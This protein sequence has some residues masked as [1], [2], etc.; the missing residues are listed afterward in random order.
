MGYTINLLPHESA[1]QLEVS[2]EQIRNRAR[3]FVTEY[4]AKGEVTSTAEGILENLQ[5]GGFWYVF[6]GVE[7]RLPEFTPVDLQSILDIAVNYA[8]LMP[9]GQGARPGLSRGHAVLHEKL[10]QKT[11][12][13]FREAL[14]PDF[15]KRLNNGRL[16]ES[17]PELAGLSDSYTVVRDV[18]VKH[19]DDLSDD[20][21][22]Q[23]LAIFKRN[24]QMVEHLDLSPFRKTTLDRYGSFLERVDAKKGDNVRDLEILVAPYL[25][26]LADLNEEWEFEIPPD[27]PGGIKEV[28][29]KPYINQYLQNSDFVRNALARALFLISESDSAIPTV[30]EYL[31]N[32]QELVDRM[33]ALDKHKS[34]RK[35]ILLDIHY[36]DKASD[37]LSPSAQGELKGILKAERRAKRK[38]QRKIRQ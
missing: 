35:R 2:R 36:S 29:A 33:L 7:K 20:F 16:W 10:V 6:D 15:E 9:L 1:E 3:D 8:L 14:T 30:L 19:Y 25:V 12:S 4:R 23:G 32:P 18:L 5:H 28:F 38:R 13:I 37:Y 24:R 11:D 34:E 21:I 31:P 27:S 26:T 22:P 17:L